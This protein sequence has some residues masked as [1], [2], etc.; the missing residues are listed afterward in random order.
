[1]DMTTLTLVQ[2]NSIL[3]QI[4][5]DFALNE[6][7]F[8][9]LI[10]SV[11]AKRLASAIN[12]AKTDSGARLW[13]HKTIAPFRK[14]ME[15]PPAQAAPQA[16]RN[17]PPQKPAAVNQAPQQSAPSDYE[18]YA[19]NAGTP[20]PQQK[21]SAQKP[22]PAQS[23]TAAADKK[24]IGHSVFGTKAALYFGYDKTRSDIHTLRIDAASSVGERKFDWANKIGIQI[25]AQELPVIAALFCGLIDRCEFKNHGAKKNKGFKIEAQP[26]RSGKGK[27]FFFN[28]SEAGKSLK[29]AP[30]GAED[31]FFV[32][33]LVL[34]QLAKNSPELDGTVLLTSLKVFASMHQ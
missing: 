12:L 30:V 22:A 3:Q 8:N 13:L 10:S 5:S 11:S 18:Q 16:A 20:A 14:E 27:Q 21:R 6:E 24:F 1:M 9:R 32:R 23:P 31:A 26:N 33:N 28:V 29:A 7:T 15:N 25:T 2:T 34:S 17:T 4:G 19:Q